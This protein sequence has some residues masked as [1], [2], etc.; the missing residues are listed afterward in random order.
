MCRKKTVALASITFY[1]YPSTKE[2]YY[3]MAKIQVNSTLKA[4]LPVLSEGEFGFCTDTG[5]IFI[6]SQGGNIQIGS[7]DDIGILSSQMDDTNKAEGKILEVNSNGKFTFVDKPGGAISLDGLSDVDLTTTPPTNGDILKYDNGVWK[8]KVV[9][10]S[11]VI[12]AYTVELER[13]GIKNN[14][15]DAV[16]TS[17]GINNALT[18][19]SEQGFAEV[20]LPKGIYLIDENNPVE[21]QSFM[22]LNLNGAT[23]R[24]RDNG[25]TGYSIVNFQRNQQFSRITNGKIEGDKDTHDYTTIQHTH[26]WGH[27]I[28]VDNTPIVGSNVRFISIDNL[29]IF[30]CTGDGIALESLYG[31]IPGYDFAGKFEKG[32]ISTTNGTL[33]VDANKIRSSIKID[34]NQSDIAEWG[35]FGLYGDSYGGL[36]LGI[37]SN[38]YDVIFYNKDNTFHSAKTKMQFFDEVEVPRGASYAKVVIRQSTVPTIGQST[39]TLKVVEFAKHVY[40]EKCN[41]HHCRRLGISVSGAKHV[42]IK[43]CEIHHIKGT[44]PQGAIDIE[45]MYNFNQYIYIDNNNIHDNASYNIVIV[46]ARH[47]SITNN[48]INGGT[49]AI[50]DNVDKVKIN[51][52]DFRD[53]GGAIAAEVIFSNNYLYGSTIT[54]SAGSKEALINNCSF[55]NSTLRIG[56][57]KA[58]CVEVDNCKFLNDSDFYYSFSNLGATIGFSIEPQTISNCIVEGGG[59]QGTSLIGV[60]NDMKNGWM[61]NNVSFVNT[62]HNQNIVTNLPPGNYTGCRFTNPGPISLINNSQA[63]YGFNGCSFEWDT[64]TLF[65]INLKNKVSLFK[66]T[67][68]YFMGKQNSTFFF[69]DIGGKIMLINNI[70]NYPTSTSTGPMIDFWWPTFVSESILIDGNTFTSNQA[71][72]IVNVS[73]PKSSSTEILFK[74]NYVKTAVVNLQNTPMHTKTNNYIDGVLDPYYKMASPPAYGIYRIGQLLYNSNPTAGGYVGWVCTVGG[75]AEDTAWKANTSYLINTLVFANANVYKCVVAGTS[76]AA[77]PSHTSATSTDGSIVWEYVDVLTV[78]KPFGLITS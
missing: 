38:L 22:T 75:T 11:N 16:N 77:A 4:N 26:E 50:N 74:N 6:G 10:G 54:L 32:G 48:A 29:D 62:K 39:V 1:E 45:D 76:A 42:Y 18:W 31:Q 72:K 78:F 36:G 12:K 3:K 59:V 66:I 2:V 73:D 15:T 30:N 41:I 60:P 9:G 44:A 21:P 67:N 55:H 56:R 40:I 25:L 37:T 20:I 63:E 58:Y 23:L 46:A 71:M 28:K 7:L 52:N 57:N 5:E 19:A 65:T 33:V 69:W 49:L 68:S 34:L 47:I 27:G 53:V 61:L 35:Y 51:G 17:K 8:P 43:E 24:I 64:Y 14:K 70:F 13:W